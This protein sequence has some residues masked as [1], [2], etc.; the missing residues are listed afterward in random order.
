MLRFDAARDIKKLIVP[1]ATAAST[2]N[3]LPF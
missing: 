2:A 1:T 3:D